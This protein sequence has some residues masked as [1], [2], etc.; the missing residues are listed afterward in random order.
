MHLSVIIMLNRVNASP[1]NAV[2][3]PSPM[4]HAAAPAA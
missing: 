1:S 3:S 2:P 4:Q